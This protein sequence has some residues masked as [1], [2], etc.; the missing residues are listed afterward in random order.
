MNAVTLANAA[1]WNLDKAKLVAKWNKREAERLRA[2]AQQCLQRL[3][4][5][6]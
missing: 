5:L 6:S 2:N 3:K 1:R 4:D